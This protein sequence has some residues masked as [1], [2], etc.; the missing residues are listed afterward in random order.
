[1]CWNKA[2]HLKDWRTERGGERKV[3]GSQYPFK[4]M[5]PI[6]SLLSISPHSL[7]VPSLQTSFQNL[8]FLLVLCELLQYDNFTKLFTSFAL[9]GSFGSIS[10]LT[11]FFFLILIN[12]TEYTV[13]RKRDKHAFCFLFTSMGVLREEKHC[14]THSPS[15]QIF[16]S[17]S[18]YI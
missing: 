12:L 4:G 2:V 1:M 17:L 10:G 16:S 14:H 7:Q 8:L 3:P 13:S 6:N 9:P 11:F 18:F 5:P 15:K